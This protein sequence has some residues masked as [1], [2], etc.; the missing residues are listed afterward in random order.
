[1][2]I[3]GNLKKWEESTT[4]LTLTLEKK[5]LAQF[6]ERLDTSK[7]YSIEIKEIKRKRSLDQNRYFWKLLDEIDT[8]INGRPYDSWQ[9]YLDCLERANIKY[10]IVFIPKDISNDSKREMLENYRATKYMLDADC[11]GITVEMYRC[12][13]GQSKMNTKEM[14]LL[15]DTALDMAAEA[16]VPID[17]W[18]G[19]LK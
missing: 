15:I 7:E 1:M 18:E 9:V 11:E 5:A 2:K 17:Y 19:V 16:G 4:T 12:Y 8:A 3:L 13:I 14:S 10:E 6:G